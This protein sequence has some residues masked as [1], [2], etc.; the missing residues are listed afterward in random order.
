MWE[1]KEKY[2]KIANRHWLDFSDC[3]RW[4]AVRDALDKT[5]KRVMFS[6]MIIDF[7]NSSGPRVTQDDHVFLKDV[8]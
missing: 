6:I 7:F 5:K 2:L 1:H 4:P 3:I 8:N